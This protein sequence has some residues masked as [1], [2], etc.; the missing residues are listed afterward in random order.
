MS[1][2]ECMTPADSIEALQFYFSHFDFSIA[3]ETEP[4]G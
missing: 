2:A 4:D 3:K 1:P